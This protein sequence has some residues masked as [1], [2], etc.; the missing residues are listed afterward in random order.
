L[1]HVK[2]LDRARIV[3]TCLFALYL[4]KWYYMQPSG[5]SEMHRGLKTS[6]ASSNQR[7]TPGTTQSELGTTN[8]WKPLLPKYSK[9]LPVGLVA[10]VIFSF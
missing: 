7:N 5:G 8:S 3:A 6:G 1:V 2:D 10:P 9:L 4:T